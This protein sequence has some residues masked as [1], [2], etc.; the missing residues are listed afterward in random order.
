[1]ALGKR[2]DV[3]AEWKE[4]IAKDEGLREVVQGVVQ[5]V[6]VAEKDEALAGSFSPGVVARASKGKCPQGLS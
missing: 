6:L 5:E 1:M 4:L 2:S 3:V